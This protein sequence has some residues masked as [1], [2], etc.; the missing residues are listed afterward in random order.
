MMQSA[1]KGILGL[2]SSY[3][4]EK[5]RWN[6]AHTQGAYV[7]SQ[8]IMANQKTDILSIKFQKNRRGKD[9]FYIHVNKDNLLKEGHEL[10]G[11]LLSSF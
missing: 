1:R 8:Y 7:I 10:I 11:K 4:E 5:H 3:N 2:E 9:D 6:Q